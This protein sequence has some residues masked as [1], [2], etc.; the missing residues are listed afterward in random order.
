VTVWLRHLEDFDVMNR[1][2]HRAAPW[3]AVSTL[4][5]SPLALV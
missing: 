5:A 1:A 2:Y 4:L 3:P